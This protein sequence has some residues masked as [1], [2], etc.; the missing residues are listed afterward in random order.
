MYLKFPR[1]AD[2]VYTRLQT[3][4]SC[5]F[6]HASSDTVS[7]NNWRSNICTVT[8]VYPRVL[9]FSLYKAFCCKLDI[10]SKNKYSSFCIWLFGVKLPVIPWHIN[11][12]D[13]TKITWKNIFS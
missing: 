10:S 3:V 5:E 9:S 2:N 13:N 7:L 11:F 8:D 1:Y 4:R 6:R 12:N